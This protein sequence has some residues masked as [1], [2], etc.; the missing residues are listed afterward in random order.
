MKFN[1]TENELITKDNIGDRKIYD[2]RSCAVVGVVILNK[3]GIK[4]ILMGQR[5]PGTP[6]FQGHWNMPCG[7]LDKDESGTEAIHREIFEETMVDL[8]FLMGT[9]KIIREDLDQPWY[10]NHYTDSNRQN[11]TLRFGIE[12]DYSADNFPILSNQYSEPNE[13]SDLQW[14]KLEDIL[15]LEDVA[16]GHKQV[17]QDY[18][19]LGEKNIKNIKS[20][21]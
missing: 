2:S 10:V 4:Y 19:K 15:N 3:N 9:N 12:I 17:L 16:F 11:I 13:V 18:I 7:Y 20:N 8:E 6:D 21:K 1:N 14:L 5:G